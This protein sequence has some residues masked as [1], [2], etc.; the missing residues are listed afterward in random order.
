M[1]FKDQRGS[2]ENQKMKPREERPIVRQSISQYA[3]RLLRL[4][5]VLHIAQI[6]LNIILWNIFLWNLKYLWM[7]IM[8]L[9]KQNYG[10]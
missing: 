4:D 9:L 1:G 3:V 7:A 2:N 6:V 5:S 8:H 10:K